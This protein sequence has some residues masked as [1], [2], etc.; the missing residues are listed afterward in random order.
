MGGAPAIGRAALGPAVSRTSTPRRRLG[1]GELIHVSARRA[2]STPIAFTW[3]GRH[4]RIAG[5]EPLHSWFCTARG[6]DPAR[7][8]QVRTSEGLRAVLAHDPTHGRWK[9][10]AVLDGHGG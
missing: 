10:E 6:R 9:M 3:R 7:L 4:Y 2:A 8:Y 1:A 5:F